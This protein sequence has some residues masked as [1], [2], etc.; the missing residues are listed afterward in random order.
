VRERDAEI[1]NTG[2]SFIFIT[3]L[4]AYESWSN[5][6][7]SPLIA[8]YI[9]DHSSV[10]RLIYGGDYINQPESKATAINQ[11]YKSV[12]RCR[13]FDNAVFMRGNHESNP[14]GTGQLTSS[15]IYAIINKHIEQYVNTGGHNYYYFD[16]ESQKVRFVVLDT[17][18]DG[19]I[20]STQLQWFTGTVSNLDSAWGVVIL[21]H[22]AIG[23]AGKDNRADITESAVVAKVRSAVANINATVMC[24]ICGHTH[25]DLSEKVDSFP[26]ISVTCDARGAQ[27]SARSTDDRTVGTINEQA[28]DVFHIDSANKKVYATRIGG[29]Q[30]NVRGT[31]DY[32][33]NDREWSYN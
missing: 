11:I 22:F 17:G 30:Y 23:S 13:V 3:D 10:D 19:D 9:V 4:H 6:Y 8:K 18:E 21:S 14:Y 26:I 33:D 25:L 12:S 32:T 28:F 1:G 7:F 5:Q 16:N 2:I 27:A 24:W 20:D 31:G 29:G 15:E